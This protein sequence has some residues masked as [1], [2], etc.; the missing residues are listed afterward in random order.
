MRPA[1]GPL[2]YPCQNW[3]QRFNLANNNAE[4]QLGAVFMSEITAKTCN[5]LEKT[6]VCTI[7]HLSAMISLGES[8]QKKLA[9]NN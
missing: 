7:L 9:A 4:I 8:I 2:R 1:P 6:F 5:N 3:R